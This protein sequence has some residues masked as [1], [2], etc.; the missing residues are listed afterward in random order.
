MERYI[1]RSEHDNSS[2]FV[3]PVE[4]LDRSPLNAAEQRLEQMHPS[5]RNNCT[6]L[7]VIESGWPPEDA[8]ARL[9]RT[10]PKVEVR[11]I[12]VGMEV[13]P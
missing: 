4:V 8:N 3:V 13:V 12:T 10:Q 7:L 5:S 9:Y 1:V 2:I 11:E 6:G